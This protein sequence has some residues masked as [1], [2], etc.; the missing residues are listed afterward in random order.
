MFLFLPAS[1]L[2]PKRAVCGS[3][4]PADVFC[5]AYQVFSEYLVRG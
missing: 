4:Q 5:L 2:R 3:V 1:K